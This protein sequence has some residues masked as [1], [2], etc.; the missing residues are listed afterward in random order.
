MCTFM[1]DFPS[2]YRKAFLRD[3]LMVCVGLIYFKEGIFIFTSNNTLPKPNILLM[4]EI[5]LTTWDGPKTPINNGISATNLT[6]LN[7]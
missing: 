2:K 6:N 4:A 1:V 7:W 5:R 3:Q